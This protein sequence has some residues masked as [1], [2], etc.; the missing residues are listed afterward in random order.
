MGNVLRMEKRQQIQALTN[1]GWGIR[2]ISRATGINRETVAKYRKDPEKRGSE[3]F[4]SSDQNQPKVPTDSEALSNQNQPEV[5][6]DL[7][8]PPPTHSSTL[9]IFTGTIRTMFLQHLT[10]QR[11][12]QDLVEEHGYKG[13]YDS[14][15]RYVKKLRKRIRHFT[16]RLPHLPGR[17]AQVDFGKAP[18]RVKINGVYKRVWLFK[19]TLSCSKHAYEELVERQDL[20]TFIR[21]HERAFAFFGGVPEIVTLDNLK[22]GVIQASL[23]DPV[24]NQTYCAFATHWGFAANP[25]IPRKPEHKG[26]VE[27]DIGYTKHNALDGRVFESL[28][29]ANLFLCHWNKRWARTRIHGTTKCQV[30]KLF[31]ELEKSRLRPLA[32]SLFEYFNIGKRKVDVNGLVEVEARYYGVP[33]RYVGETVIVHHNQQ[34]VK[35]LSGEEV[36]ITHSRL[37][38]RGKISMPAE[39]LPHWKH[40]SLESQERFYCRKAREIGPSMH[41]IVY[42]A[43]GSDDPL[44]IRRVRGLLSLG[45][46]YGPAIAERAAEHVRT[47][48][49]SNYY[50]VKGLCEKLKNEYADHNPLAGQLTQHHDLIRPLTEYDQIINRERNS[51]C[52]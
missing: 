46:S 33:P 22:S 12:Y 28:E 11:I 20:E 38:G 5:P 37:A 17:E 39:C 42:R 40:P 50:M 41:D 29:E 52:P 34:Y 27:R 13:S 1:L 7:P 36:I 21:C 23:Y 15:K 30:W 35:I 48:K 26:V 14:I 16:E 10:A 49:S 18:C 25:C 24:L 31:T 2:A 4:D 44:A 45:R 19:M 3:V 43:L 32:A 47:L 9:Q 6:A 8:Q 51:V